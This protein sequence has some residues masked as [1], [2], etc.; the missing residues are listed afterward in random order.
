[1]QQQYD[2]MTE[3]T[4]NTYQIGKLVLSFKTK[5]TATKNTL[6]TKTQTITMQQTKAKFQLHYELYKTQSNWMK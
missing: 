6:Q 3:W 5:P 1:M 4:V 2:M